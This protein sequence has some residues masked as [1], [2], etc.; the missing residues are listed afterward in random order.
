MTIKETVYNHISTLPKGTRIRAKHLWWSLF[1]Y[2]VNRNSVTYALS[3]LAK[4]GIV[5]KST[6]M[7]GRNSEWKKI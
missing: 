3:E 5:K 7:R 1:R 6:K 2:K 4:E